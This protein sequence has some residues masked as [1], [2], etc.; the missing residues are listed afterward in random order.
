[1][2]GA[3]GAFVVWP[4]LLG[5]V[6]FGAARTPI[7]I[8]SKRH[9]ETEGDAYAGVVYSFWEAAGLSS[10]FVNLVSPA[11]YGVWMMARRDESIRA[12]SLEQA[13]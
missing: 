9:R 7:P 11:F 12:Y 4:L 10:V 13:S 6:F 2:A 1:V 8:A 3:A 5:V